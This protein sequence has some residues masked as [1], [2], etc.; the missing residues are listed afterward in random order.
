MLLSGEKTVETR[1]YPLPEK[2]VGCELAIIETPGPR[3]R[4]EAGIEKARIVGTIVPATG[5]CDRCTAAVGGRVAAEA[6]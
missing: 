6:R 3:G 2:Y 1:G 4:R 5:L